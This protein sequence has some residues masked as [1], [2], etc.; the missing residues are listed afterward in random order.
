MKYFDNSLCGVMS[1]VDLCNLHVNQPPYL[2]DYDR[3]EKTV[4]GVI[5]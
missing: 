4:K 5:L 2:V 3:Y 1:L